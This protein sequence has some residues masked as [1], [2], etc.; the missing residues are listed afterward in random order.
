MVPLHQAL[1][2]MGWPQPRSPIQCDNSTAIG[3]ANETIIP[4]KKTNGHAF[5]LV[6]MQRCSRPIQI[7]LGT[8]PRQSWR[9][10]HQEPPFN[11]PPL[12]MEDPTYC[13]IL[14]SAHCKLVFFLPLLSMLTARVCRY[15]GITPVSTV[16]VNIICLRSVLCTSQD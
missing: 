10:Q 1:I 6:T 11:L 7:L 15:T 2:E 16:P 13:P 14:P 12:P 4:Q 5:P 8:W 9:L 3:V